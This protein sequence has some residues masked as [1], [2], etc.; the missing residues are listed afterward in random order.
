MKQSYADLINLYVKDEK[1]KLKVFDRNGVYLPAKKIGK[2]NPK[3]EEIKEDN[4]VRTQ[5][6]QTVDQALICGV[7]EQ[8]IL[9][10]KREQ[11]SKIAYQS[12]R[13][14]GKQPGLFSEIVLRTIETLKLMIEKIFKA[15]VQKPDL[16]SELWA[17]APET[18][19]EQRKTDKVMEP[20]QTV[21]KT[22]QM[23]QKKMVRDEM[24]ISEAYDQTENRPPK[25]PEKV[26]RYLRLESIYKQLQK[27]NRAI[28]SKEEEI[29]ILEQ[30]LVDIK[31]IF[32]G[33]Q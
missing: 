17:N 3:A 30:Q 19:K 16:G 15:E 6:N 26:S 24:E 27:Q 32:K 5:W 13:T 28:H 18:E 21:Q 1:E 25:Q 20:E 22:V 29:E 8:K 7:S 9:W 11:I 4:E 23:P 12:T 33:K 10:V 31:G 2:N 14:G